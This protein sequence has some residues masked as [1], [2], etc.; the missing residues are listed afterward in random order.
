MDPPL[1]EFPSHIN[2]AKM[3]TKSLTHR[4]FRGQ[5]ISNDAKMWG[6]LIAL[7]NDGMH[8]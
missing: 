5:S 4:F 6:F 2:Y 7:S 8:Y 3:G 1:K